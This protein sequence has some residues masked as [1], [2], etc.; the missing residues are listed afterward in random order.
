MQE[1]N[2][3]IVLLGYS[4]HAYVVAE[5]ALMIGLDI[6]GYAAKSEINLNP[7]NLE[8]LGNETSS[9]FG[10]WNSGAQFLL[11]IGDNYVRT[12]VAKFIREKGFDC[13]TLIH[14]E[15]SV[16]EYA[17]IGQG[18]FLARNA[19]I[20]PLCKIGKDVIIN[21]S[22]SLDHE[23]HICDGAHVA[24]GAI[25]AGNVTI[26]ENSFIGANSV[27][28]QGVSIGDHVI[29][30]AGAVV[31]EDIKSNKTVVGNPAKEIFE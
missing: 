1:T 27:V 21:T 18:T 6:K 10:E 7:F 9:G 12:K 24:P 5:A 15:S 29:V 20:N 11:G 26:G 19:T 4:G 22:A 25:L 28:K 14:P 13:L 31:L 3:H 23:C 17:K 30:G 8:Y 2:R 16:S